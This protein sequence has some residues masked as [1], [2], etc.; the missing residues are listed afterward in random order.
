MPYVQPVHRC[1]Y[2]AVAAFRLEKFLVGRKAIFIFQTVFLFRNSEIFGVYVAHGG[3]FYAFRFIK[4]IGVNR[5][6][7]A[8][9]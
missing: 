9:T 6:A 2:Y 3:Y 1:D 8:V 4:E 7:I 5:T